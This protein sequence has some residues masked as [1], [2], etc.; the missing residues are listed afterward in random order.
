M[1]TDRSVADY[2][3]ETTYGSRVYT[4]T[5]QGWYT[6][7]PKIRDRAEQLAKWGIDPAELRYNESK[8]LNEEQVNSTYGRI[9]DERYPKPYK[10]ELRELKSHL[11]TTQSHLEL[12]R[13]E[14]DSQKL[15]ND[16]LERRL[17]ALERL[18]EA[19]NK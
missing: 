8:R 10:A 9:K 7:E 5:K 19:E 17:A 15:R 4:S 3:H 1:G 14:L 13:S 18:K 6:Q 11:E 2:N 12:T 16:D